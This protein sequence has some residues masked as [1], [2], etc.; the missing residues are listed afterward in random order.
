[1]LHCIFAGDLKTQKTVFVQVYHTYFCIILYIVL[2]EREKN[3]I[4]SK[5]KQYY[6][7]S[8]KGNIIC[9]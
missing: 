4:S 2:K 6:L 8:L 1:M 7:P 9:L 5:Y 3:N